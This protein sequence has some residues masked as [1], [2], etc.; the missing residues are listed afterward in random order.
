MSIQNGMVVSMPQLAWL[1]VDQA[2]SLLELGQQCLNMVKKD[3]DK[4]L[5]ESLKLKNK[6]L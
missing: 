2:Q 3:I 5:K 4:K 1:E 6:L